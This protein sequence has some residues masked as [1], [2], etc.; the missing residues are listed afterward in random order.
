MRLQ[1]IKTKLGYTVVTL[2]QEDIEI[3]DA[4]T[5]DLLSDVMGNAPDNSVLITIQGHK[6]SIAVASL[7][8]MPAIILCNKRSAPQDMVAAAISESIAIFSTSDNQF[9]ASCKIGSLL[10]S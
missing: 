5:S 6:N 3:S 4:Y 1:D 7:I 2:P 8:G 10:N 9:T